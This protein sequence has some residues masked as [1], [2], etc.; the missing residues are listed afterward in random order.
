MMVVICRL[1]SF[2]QGDFVLKI[3]PPLG[4]SFGKIQLHIHNSNIICLGNAKTVSEV[5]CII[6][7]LTSM[8]F[9]L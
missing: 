4:W 8:S 2:T 9:G 5:V 7:V 6:Y 1:V 3:E